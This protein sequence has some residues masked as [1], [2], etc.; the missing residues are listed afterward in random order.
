[1]KSFRRRTD[2]HMHRESRGTRFGRDP[3]PLMAAIM[4]TLVVAGIRFLGFDITPAHVA[5]VIVGALATQWVCTRLTGLPRFDPMSALISGLGLSL[6]AR[7]D[8]LVLALTTAI[9]SIASKF[10]LRWNGKHVW[11][12][13]NL[14]LIL[15]VLLTGGAPGRPGLVWV[16]PGQWGDTA[17]FAFA[18]ASIGLVLVFRAARSDVTLAFFAAWALILFLR[19]AWLGQPW[20]I[21]LHQL[22]N[23]AL[24]LFAFF[25][26]S[27]PR[28]TPD[29]RAGR[30]LFGLIVAL[31]AGLLQFVAYRPNGPLW[32]LAACAPLVPLL[33]RALPGP[34]HAWSGRIPPAAPPRA[35]PRESKGVPDEGPSAVPRPRAVPAPAAGA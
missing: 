14:G 3:R 9:L 27:D 18:L 35:E 6:L 33:D 15:M 25:M 13:T 30:I 10:V 2:E 7:T 5:T 21:P 23:G 19:A 32:A 22:R 11:N 31:G 26:I 20:A 4:A 8:S 1:M 17:I 12:P 34:R 24:I 29:S 28:T 16:S